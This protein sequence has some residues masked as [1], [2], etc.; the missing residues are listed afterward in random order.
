MYTYSCISDFFWIVQNKIPA[1]TP[2]NNIKN[3]GNPNATNAP[4][5]TKPI[6]LARFCI[7]FIGPEEAFALISVSHSCSA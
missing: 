1:I 2:P 4:Q 6:T 5:I 3:I 7:T